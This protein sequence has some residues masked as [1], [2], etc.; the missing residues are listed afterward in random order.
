M[1]NIDES[2]ICTHCT[3]AGT[4]YPFEIFPKKVQGKPMTQSSEYIFTVSFK[5]LHSQRLGS[6][7][8]VMLI[9]FILP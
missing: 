8:K 4:F 5:Y 6:A 3:I 2:N 1:L 9:A 7:R